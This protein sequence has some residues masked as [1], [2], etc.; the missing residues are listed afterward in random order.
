MVLRLQRVPDAVFPMHC[1]LSELLTVGV[2]A[3][4]IVVD[5]DLIPNA[6]LL[7]FGWQTEQ[8]VYR[9]AIAFS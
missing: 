3:D 7:V 2:V 6:L 1:V 5:V 9:S 8:G 4:F